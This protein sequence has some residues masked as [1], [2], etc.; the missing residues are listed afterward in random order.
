[1]VL[2]QPGTIVN[3]LTLGSGSS[4]RGGLGAP[5]IISYT[6]PSAP[7]AGLGSTTA[8]T[9]NSGTAGFVLTIGGTGITSTGT[10]TMPAAAHGWLCDGED[11][12]TPG[13]ARTTGSLSTT[14]TTLTFYNLTGT[15]TAPTSGD[16]VGIKCT[17]V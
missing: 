1:M 10:V 9:Y 16:L 11:M 12:T 13:V 6:A 3:A 17:G 14:S 7:S 2:G 15:A 8:V 5:T 4:L